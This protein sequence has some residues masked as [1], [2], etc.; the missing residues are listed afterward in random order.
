MVDALIANEVILS[1]VTPERGTEMAGNPPTLTVKTPFGTPGAVGANVT[2]MVHAALGASEAPQVLDWMLKGP[3]EMDT[4]PRT[5]GVAP[6]LVS[7][8]V[9]PALVVP[10]ACT[11]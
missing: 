1:G 2:V 10:T 11:G 9:C 4:F 6:K 7:A 8:T 5:I 3:G